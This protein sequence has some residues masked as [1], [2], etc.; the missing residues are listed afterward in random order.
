[1][2]SNQHEDVGGIDSSQPTLNSPQQPPKPVPAP[3]H[4]PSPKTQ[5]PVTQPSL[6]DFACPTRST[7]VEETNPNSRISATVVPSV[8]FYTYV[9]RKKKRKRK[10]EI[11]K[12][13]TTHSE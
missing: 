7:G 13:A 1:M 9:W 10:E 8:S 4:K 3:H 11:G 5:Q 12:E 6:R 2:K